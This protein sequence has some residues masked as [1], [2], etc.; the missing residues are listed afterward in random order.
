MKEPEQRI[1]V[2]DANVLINLI[3]V[4]RLDLCAGLPSYK[5]VVP[6]HVLE[7]ITEPNQRQTMA[8]AI[9]KG[10]FNVGSITNLDSIALY[11]EL[12]TILDPG[13][14]ACIT[15]AVEHGWMVAS[16]E[17]NPFRREAVNRI[18]ADRLIG[19]KEIYL[20]AISIGALSIDDADADKA[21]L[22]TR[23]FKMDFASF[24]DLIP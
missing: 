4:S 12:T 2:T 3:H 11:D 18:G 20:K 24:R 23:R 17:K 15:L 10:I 5:F 8:D 16:D 21:V 22:E 13:E 14:S 1:V 6:D 9:T 7:E 19:I